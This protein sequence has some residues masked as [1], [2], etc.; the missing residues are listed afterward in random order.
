MRPVAWREERPTGLR[1]RVS[2]GTGNSALG[3]N[4]RMARSGD[5]LLSGR[6][7]HSRKE[8]DGDVDGGLSPCAPRSVKR[9]LRLRPGAMPRLASPT[10]GGEGFA[11][12]MKAK[13]A[14]VGACVMV[15][16]GGWG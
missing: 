10:G 13:A 12:G 1:G 2:A 15:G 3:V 5:G 16:V 9:G 4:P 6:G 11:M 8:V 14:L 7:P